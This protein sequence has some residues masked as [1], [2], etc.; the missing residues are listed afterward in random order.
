MRQAGVLAAAGLYALKNNLQRLAEDHENTKLFVKKI[1]AI[2]GLTID[3]NSIQTNMVIINTTLMP[4]VELVAKCKE[5]GLLFNA[6]G[7]NRVRIVFHLDISRKQVT[8][9]ADILKNAVK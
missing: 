8:K 3:T 7:K 4:A 1:E 2:P 9:A 6:I 5:K